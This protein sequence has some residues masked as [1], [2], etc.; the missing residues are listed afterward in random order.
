ML[1]SQLRRATSPPRSDVLSL[2]FPAK[3]RRGN[4][5]FA[6]KEGTMYIHGY[7]MTAN[8]GNFY[9]AAQV[10]K[11]ASEQRA[12]DVR[13]SLLKGA[14]E[15]EGAAT[16][17]ETFMVGQWLDSRHSQVESEAQYHASAAGK[18]PDFG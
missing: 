16:P 4:C 7:S 14:A 12:A 1:G 2:I 3:F 11:T 15:I 6:H 13:K 5:P 8:E 18:V 9:S 17:E 10:E